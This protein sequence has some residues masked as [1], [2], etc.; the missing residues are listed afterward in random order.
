MPIYKVQLNGYAIIA[1][2][3]GLKPVTGIGLAYYEPQTNRTAETLDTVLL[4]N[5]FH[6]PFM[7][8]LLEIELNPVKIVLPLLKEVRK[9]A[10][11]IK[12]P[13]G[14]DDCEDCRRLEK[15]MGFLK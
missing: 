2:N 8:H 3:C 13:D 15:I 14:Y 11:L 1:E 10:D 6:M 9:L 12:P 5:G 4:E 7:A